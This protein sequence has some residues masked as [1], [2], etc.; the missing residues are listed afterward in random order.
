MKKKYLELKPKEV[1]TTEQKEPHFSYSQ[2]NTYQR[3][4][5][6]YEYAYIEKIK[7]PPS[8]PLSS[9]KAIHETLEYNSLWK[10][11]AQEDLP[12][13][14]LLDISSDSHDKYMSQVEPESLT[15]AAAF[16]KAVGQN[17]DENQGIVTIYRRTQAPE[18]TPIAVE[19]PFTVVL[20]ED[21]LGEYLPVIGFVDS[22]AEIPDPRPGPKGGR[23]VALEDYKRISKRK[24]QNEVD[25]SPQLTL[26]D[27]VYNMQ[28]D[29]TV[30]VLGLR[31][32]GATKKDGPYSQPIYRT[33]QTMEQRT[34]RWR[35]VLNQMKGVQRS[36]KHDMET[37]YFAPADDPKVCGWCGYKYIC[38]V[39][40]EV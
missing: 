17:K 25:L 32:L 26:Y 14:D 37:G 1:N 27:Y 13:A 24:S 21:D 29:L 3:C 9:G 28:T 15:S 8:I 23:V 16:K 19:H 36:I 34:N 11:K 31:Q 22:Y 2:M 7:S 5:K 30:D 40:P 35:R 18:I 12:M 4:P 38:Q 20:P 6:Q 33:H 39:K 10:M